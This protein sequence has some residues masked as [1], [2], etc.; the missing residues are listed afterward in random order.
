[1]HLPLESS[2]LV[3]TGTIVLVVSFVVFGVL[4]IWALVETV[5]RR[6]WLYT[7]GVLLLGPIG[8]LL[9][10]FIGR[11]ETARRSQRDND[12]RMRVT[13]SG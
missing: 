11:P 7:L 9:R 5:V 6:Q 13:H 2:F 1:M 4:V 10:F 8:G 3:S 12:S